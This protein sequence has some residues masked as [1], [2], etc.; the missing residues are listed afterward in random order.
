MGTAFHR[1]ITMVW[2]LVLV[3]L[4]SPNFAAF[5]EAQPKTHDE[6]KIQFMAGRAD[7]AEFALTHGLSTLIN[8]YSPWLRAS[9]TE[10]PGMLA[11]YELV[12]K[13]PENKAKSIICGVVG[14][15]SLFGKT[16]DEG[17]FSWGPYTDHRFVARLN[18]TIHTLVTLDENIK[19]LED[20]KGKKLAD[21]RKVST[22]FY[23]N[24]LIFK[25]AGILDSLKIS[26]G[27]TGRGITVLRDG[28]VDVAVALGIGPVE[29]TT[30]IPLP[31]VQ[32]LLAM[33]KVYF[34][35]YDKEAFEKAIK[36]DNVA[37]SPVT[38]PAKILGE[39]QTEPTLVKYDPL[40]L[41]ADK[42]MDPEVI[43]ELLR[44]FDEHINELGEFSVTGKWLKRENL[45]TSGYQAEDNYH[46]GAVKYYKEN[47]IKIRVNP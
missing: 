16:K 9:V 39:Y 42:S 17:G 2:L 38:V 19:T 11:N 30:W 6:F 34:V 7:S 45:G 14:G 28:L 31:P 24:R 8:K 5:S 18:G 41:L 23:E 44:I 37:T 29:P 47:G 3:G 33:K 32:Q 43:Y 1:L 25:H 22:R 40:S 35:S 27:G 36:Q 10:T 20:M 46:P 15:A 21:G 13:K 12:A 4:F 26:Y